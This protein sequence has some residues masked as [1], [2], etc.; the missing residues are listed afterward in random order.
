MGT[1]T[2]IYS[3]EKFC[4]H[5]NIDYQIHILYCYPILTIKY[6]VCIVIHVIHHTSSSSKSLAIFSTM[7]ILSLGVWHVR[8]WGEYSFFSKKFIKVSL[9]FDV[10]TSHKALQVEGSSLMNTDTTP[11]NARFVIIV[12]WST[13]AFFHLNIEH[14]SHFFLK[15]SFLA[16]FHMTNNIRYVSS[17]LFHTW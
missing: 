1:Y 9:Q 7:I 17:K 6:I 15:Y 14:E 3:T 16:T 13:M 11:V 10:N 4:Q 8:I 2:C 5:T 12:T